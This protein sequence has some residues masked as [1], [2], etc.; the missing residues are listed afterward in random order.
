MGRDKNDSREGVVA[1]WHLTNNRPQFP[2][3]AKAKFATEADGWLVAYA[4][5]H[6]VAVVT[7]EQP[8]PNSRSR[9]LLPDVCEQFNVTYK[10]TFAM[11]HK[12]AVRFRED[13]ARRGRLG[14]LVVRAHRC[15]GPRRCAVNPHRWLGCLGA[16]RVRPSLGVPKPSSSCAPP[17]STT[18]SAPA[19]L[20]G[21]DVASNIANRSPVAARFDGPVDSAGAFRRI[22]V[23][24]DGAIAEIGERF[25]FAVTDP[26]EPDGEIALWCP[27]GP[28]RSGGVR[29]RDVDAD[30]VIVARRAEHRRNWD[31]V[32][33]AI[34]G[35]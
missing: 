16:A 29:Q 2:D 7:N 21:P 9:I 3:L 19:G 6:G 13:A 32:N 23:P 34:A 5:V 11:L 4:I 22:G 33:V 10:D 31:L 28:A 27:A 35:A 30:I 26:V 12:L 14:V 20:N 8:Q 25:S 15:V 18:T 24:F 1:A 17:S